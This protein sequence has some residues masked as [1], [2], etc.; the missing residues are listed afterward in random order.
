MATVIHNNAVA[1]IIEHQVLFLRQTITTQ[2]HLCQYRKEMPTDVRLSMFMLV[3]GDKQYLWLQ[4][5]L[6]LLSLTKPTRIMACVKTWYSTNVHI[7]STLK[8]SLIKLLL[9]QE[10]RVLVNNNCIIVNRDVFLH[11]MQYLSKLVVLSSCQPLLLTY[12]LNYITHEKEIS[13]TWL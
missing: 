11:H 2:C 13:D 10:L 8:F 12:L 4:P 6:P 5:P 3:G 7:S 9:P 1:N